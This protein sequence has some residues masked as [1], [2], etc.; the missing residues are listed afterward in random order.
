MN[1]TIDLI[2]SNNSN[3]TDLILSNNSNNGSIIELFILEKEK[4]SINTARNYKQTI[5]EFFNK[6]IIDI[7]YTDLKSVDIFKAKAYVKWLNSRGLKGSTIHNKISALSSLYDWLM[8]FNTEDKTVISTNYF[9][10]LKDKGPIEDVNIEFLDEKEIKHLLKS[11][12]TTDI[13]DLRDK[14]LLS[15]AFSTGLRVSDLVNINMKKNIK[16][17]DGQYALVFNMKKVKRRH[18]SKIQPK[19]KKLIDLYL[20]K[21]NRTYEDDDYLFKAHKGKVNQSLSTR[22]V[23]NLID[24]RVRTAGINKHI[25]PHGAR[26]SAITMAANN[27]VDLVRLKQFAGHKNINTTARYTH[28]TNTLKDN[29]SDDFNIL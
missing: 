27:G 24:N 11:I 20:D 29:P 5:S 22:S 14:A 7:S 1:N 8:Q 2:N 21:T 6:Q 3:N 23:A 15:L 12:G 4:N 26:H 16:K 13:I 28:L 19:V 10:N 17:F 9:S 18:V 25:T